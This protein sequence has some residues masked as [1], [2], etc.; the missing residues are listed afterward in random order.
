MNVQVDPDGTVNATLRLVNTKGVF[1][2]IFWTVSGNAKCTSFGSGTDIFEIDSSLPLGPKQQLNLC[3]A[4]FPPG[5]NATLHFRKWGWPDHPLDKPAFMMIDMIQG[6]ALAL[7]FDY[8]PRYKDDSFTEWY[9]SGGVDI[10][11]GKVK[12]VPVDLGNTIYKMDRG[13]GIG[14]VKSASAVFENYPA[15]ASEIVKVFTDI[16]V[17]PD[18]AASGFGRLKRY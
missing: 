13:D 10:L 17:D 2:D 5:S 14:A 16:E 7:G 3:S 15:A 12:S 11:A 6:F 4:S 8:F 1:Y 9:I 18:V